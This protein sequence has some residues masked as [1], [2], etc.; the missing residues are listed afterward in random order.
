MGHSDVIVESTSRDQVFPAVVA[1]VL[2]QSGIVDALYVV[3]GGHPALESFQT[4]RAG[5][6][7]LARQ[8]RFILCHKL[9]QLLWVFEILYTAWNL[10]R[11]LDIWQLWWLKQR[12]FQRNSRPQKIILWTYSLLIFVMFSRHVNIKVIFSCETLPAHFTVINK[13]ILEV[14]TARRSHLIWRLPNF[15]DKK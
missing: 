10:R 8:T 11:I 2:E 13:G 4:N 9:K 7:W 3:P 14:N 15:L 12:A 6:L 1:G 5:K